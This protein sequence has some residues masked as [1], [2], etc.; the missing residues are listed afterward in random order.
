MAEQPVP[1]QEGQE[2]PASQTPAP[3]SAEIQSLIAAEAQKLFDSRI[4]GL[5]SVYEKQISALRKDVEEARRA[6]LS[7]EEIISSDR[8]KLEQELAQARREADAL[9]AGRQYPESYPVFE[10]MSA[11]QTVEEQLE[12]LRDALVKDASGLQPA[13]A[14]SADAPASAQSPP[15][16]SGTDPNRPLRPPSTYVG[17]GS[18]MDASLA[19]Q[20]L[21]TLDRWPSR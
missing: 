11:A 19:D 7:E 13:P 3:T 8:S 15:P 12:I 21:G 6:N 14:Q 2:A 9:R 17:D 10:A 18:N 1:Q 5:Q 4:P 16:S 20:I